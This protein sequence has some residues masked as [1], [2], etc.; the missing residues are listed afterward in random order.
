MKNVNEKPLDLDPETVGNL[1][2]EQAEEI[3]GGDSCGITSCNTKANAAIA[4]N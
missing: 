4:D 1:T 2:E 3:S